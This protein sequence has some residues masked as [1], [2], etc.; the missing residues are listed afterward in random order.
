M[1]RVFRVSLPQAKRAAKAGSGWGLDE[2][3]ILA[4]LL[5]PY[6]EGRSSLTSIHLDTD[7]DIQARGY[8]TDPDAN[9]GA[10]TGY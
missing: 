9:P 3:A 6:K 1:D 10:G 5:T 4:W 7:L 8:G 2:L